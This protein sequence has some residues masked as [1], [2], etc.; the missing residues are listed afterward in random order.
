MPSLRDSAILKQG[1][2][3]LKRWAKLFR[4]Y[5][6]SARRIDLRCKPENRLCVSEISFNLPE[7]VLRLLQQIDQSAEAGF[8]GE[9]AGNVADEAAR[10]IGTLA[11]LTVLTALGM[12]ILKHALLSEMAKV[13][14]VEEISVVLSGVTR[15]R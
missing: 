3:A 10:R 11:I 4:P 1:Y 14:W 6:A 12:A 8:A 2:P 15:P 7:A 5:G 13:R 9:F